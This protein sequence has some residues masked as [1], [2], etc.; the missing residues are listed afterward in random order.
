MKET[1]IELRAVWCKTK[2]MVTLL[3]FGGRRFKMISQIQM[4][5]L[6]WL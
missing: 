1:A 2:K 6:I 5:V 4:E 3:D